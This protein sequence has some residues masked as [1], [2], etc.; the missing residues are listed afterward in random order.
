MTVPRH[1][2]TRPRSLPEQ[3]L[4]PEP[5][6]DPT[7]PEIPDEPFPEMPLP[8]PDPPAPMAPPELPAEPEQRLHDTPEQETVMEQAPVIVWNGLD[9]SPDIDRIVMKRVRTLLRHAP[10]ALG[11]TVTL[12]AAQGRQHSARG[13]EVS[14][15]LNLPGPDLD[16]RHTVRQGDT[17]ADLKIAVNGAFDALE[18][19]LRDARQRQTVQDIRQHPPILHGVIA[20]IEPELGYAM[21]RADDG[22]EVYLQ[23]DALVSGNWPDLQIGHRMRFRAMQGDKGPFAVDAAA[24]AAPHDRSA[25]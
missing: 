19:R 17:A 16:A 20:E 13:V 12:A 9:R 21:V 25:E 24:L 8:A 1:T 5:A 4:T 3:P 18:R 6:P 22:S 11:C 10:R 14:V 7:G 23:S 15:H 2:A